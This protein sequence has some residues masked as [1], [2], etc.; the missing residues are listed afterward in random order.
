MAMGGATIG[1]TVTERGTEYQRQKFRRGKGK[2]TRLLF[3]TAEIRDQLTP[4]FVYSVNNSL[5][6]NPEA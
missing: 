5:S 3:L 1:V 2:L 6:S 4:K